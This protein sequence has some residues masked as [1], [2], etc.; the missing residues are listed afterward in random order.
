[1]QKLKVSYSNQ[2]VDVFIENHLIDHIQDYLNQEEHYF[3]IT[4]QIVASKYLDSI[5]K[6]IAHYDLFILSSGELSKNFDDVKKIITHLMAANIQKKDYLLAL[7]GG[8]VGDITA[9]VASIYKR[10]VKFIAIPTTLTSQVD[11]CLGGKCG[12]DFTFNNDTYKNQIGTFYH[13]EKILVDPFLLTSLPKTEF[14]S[15]MSEV[16]KYGLCFSSTLLNKIKNDA[17]IEEV[18]FDCLQIKAKITEQDEFDQNKRLALNYGHTIGHALESLSQFSI[19]HGQAVALG[20]YYETKQ[21]SIREVLRTIYQKFSINLAFSFH[22][23]D[24][25]KFIEKDKKRNHA[26]ITV[27]IL[28]EIGVVAV[29]TIAFEEYCRGME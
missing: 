17:P 19:N 11:S 22:I 12:V 16:I 14:A 8:V 4:D 27:P 28:K 23:K 15:G 10:G 29:E 1:M 6:Q 5:I 20:L 24:I 9:F 21:P 26:M 25:I 18:I 7:G 3:I 2:T 13:P